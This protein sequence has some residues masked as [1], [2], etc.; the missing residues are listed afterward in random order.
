[1]KNIL[2]LKPF[3]MLQS[4]ME[5][6]DPS[7]DKY[8]MY[9]NMDMR[10]EKFCFSRE[11][12]LREIDDLSARLT[13]LKDLKTPPDDSFYQAIAENDTLEPLKLKG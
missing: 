4:K 6:I 5:G 9:V 13:K 12:H 1:M 8:Q 10:G 3:A 11:E 2:A 7:I